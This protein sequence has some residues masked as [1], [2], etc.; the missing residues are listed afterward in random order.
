MRLIFGVTCLRPPS[1]QSG[2][3]S[4]GPPVS[5]AFAC[6]PVFTYVRTKTLHRRCPYFDVVVGLASSYDP[7]SYAGGGL[8]TGRVSNARQVKGDGPDKKIINM[9][10][11]ND[12]T[13]A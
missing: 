12:S 9:F 6:T 1:L 5:A 10:Y 7:A 13:N 3:S 4:E 11:L 2:G 8:A